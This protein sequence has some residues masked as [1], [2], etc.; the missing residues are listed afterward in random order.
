MKEAGECWQFETGGRQYPEK[1]VLVKLDYVPNRN[2]TDITV[3]GGK[4]TVVASCL[5]FMWCPKDTTQ[6]NS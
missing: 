1:A 6:H 2:G 5:S 4:G 3:W